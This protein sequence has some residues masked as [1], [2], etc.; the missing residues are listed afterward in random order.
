MHILLDKC[1]SLINQATQAK[2]VIVT[3]ESCTAGLI[4]AAITDCAGASKAY[5]GGFI[6][7][8]NEAKKSFIA[9]SEKILEQHG[10]VSEECAIAMAQGA[11]KS[12]EQATLSIA[13]TG[14][15]GPGGGS[16][17]KPVGLV[18]ISCHNSKTNKTICTKN[19]FK[20]NRADIRQQTVD[21]AI[22]IA[23]S[24]IN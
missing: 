17:E 7:Y 14:I 24:N 15:A 6:V 5:H 4:G 2:H 16:E 13:V 23:L 19:I 1:Q 9:V 8:D 20:G 3:A 18:Y 12:Y 21:T 10:A 11:V 22:D